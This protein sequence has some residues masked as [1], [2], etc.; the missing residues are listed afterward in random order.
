MHCL[1]CGTV[2]KKIWLMK[3]WLCKCNEYAN[4]YANDCAKDCPNDCDCDC[5]CDCAVANDDC[6]ID[7]CKNPINVSKDHISLL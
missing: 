7:D 6:E 1:N 4:D 2:L 5:D 3:N